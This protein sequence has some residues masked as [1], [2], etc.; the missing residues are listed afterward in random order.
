MSAPTISELAKE[1][2]QLASQLNKYPSD[3]LETQFRD[4]VQHLCTRIENDAAEPKTF[5]IA[6]E[7]FTR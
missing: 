3:H 4:K 5:Q 2:R 7:P 1:I 6:P